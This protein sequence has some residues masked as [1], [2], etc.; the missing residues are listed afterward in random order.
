MIAG[1]STTGPVPGVLCLRNGGG[2]MNRLCVIVVGFVLAG[3]VCF[4]VGSDERHPKAERSKVDKFAVESAG[5]W[6]D[7]KASL[8]E[9]LWDLLGDLPPFFTYSKYV[10]KRVAVVGNSASTFSG[11]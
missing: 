6:E 9:K 10:A 11:E 7:A 2:M 8:R 1:D 5:Q 3:G 4:G